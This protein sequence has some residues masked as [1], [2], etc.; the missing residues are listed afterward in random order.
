MAVLLLSGFLQVSLQGTRPAGTT[1]TSTSTQ[2]RALVCGVCGGT[3]TVVGFSGLGSRPTFDT[4]RTTRTTRPTRSTSDTTRG[5]LGGKGRQGKYGLN[6]RALDTLLVDRVDSTISFLGCAWILQAIHARM[7]GFVVE[8]VSTRYVVSVHLMT[9]CS[10]TA[11]LS[12]D[13]VEL[14]RTCNLRSLRG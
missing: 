7:V 5:L 9:C 2:H 6:G 8:L 3:A 1:S 14:S 12:G 11:G 13:S 10:S 4:A